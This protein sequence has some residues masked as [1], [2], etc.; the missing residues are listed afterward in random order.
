MV[1]VWG[2]SVALG[3]SGMKSG[4]HSRAD[5][6]GATLGRIDVHG[7]RRGVFFDGEQGVLPHCPWSRFGVRSTISTCS[8]NFQ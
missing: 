3:E 2:A 5:V 1:L 4:R 6:R 8:H 7:F